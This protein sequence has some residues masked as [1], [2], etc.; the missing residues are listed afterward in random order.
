MPLSE[1]EQ[2]VLEQIERALYAD[3]PKFAAT[4]RGI[5][6]RAL[7]RRR[8]MRAVAGLVVGV[9][10]LPVG[11]AFDKYYISVAGFL[12]ALTAV[13]YGIATWRRTREPEPQ[14]A[15]AATLRAA[16][17]AATVGVRRFVPHRRP[18]AS[19]A[20]PRGFMQRMEARWNR[21]REAFGNGGSG[22][23]RRRDDFDE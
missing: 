20:R 8:Y 2:R 23:V 15:T 11:I 4:V 1:H 6:P 19:S 14:P 12:L 16:P 3:D 18:T 7:T 21:R 9:A 10:L 22:E 5:D 13:L 17:Q